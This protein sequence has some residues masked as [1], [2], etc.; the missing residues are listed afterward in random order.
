MS[1]RRKIF[2]FELTSN[3]Y[4][5]ILLQCLKKQQKIFFGAFSPIKF[6]K[7][8]YSSI[9]MSTLFKCTLIGGKLFDLFS[10]FMITNIFK[11][12]TMSY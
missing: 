9:K 6:I 3:I 8:Y 11:N 2:F 5:I 10:F 7:K 12:I 1:K 4:I